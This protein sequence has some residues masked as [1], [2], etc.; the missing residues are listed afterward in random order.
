MTD[1]LMTLNQ[2]ENLAI[3]V[4]IS[5]FVIGV[6]LLSPMTLPQPT[7]SRNLRM[8]QAKKWEKDSTGIWTLVPIPGTAMTK[9]TNAGSGSIGKIK[10]RMCEKVFHSNAE[11]LNNKECEN[12]GCKCINVREAMRQTEQLLDKVKKETKT[13]IHAKICTLPDD[14]ADTTIPRRYVT[15]DLAYSATVVPKKDFRQHR[16]GRRK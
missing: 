14:C 13:V 5:T 9:A 16:R 7:S 11:Y 12:P 1:V 8:N 4:L 15:V 2:P 3:L 10:C 6:L